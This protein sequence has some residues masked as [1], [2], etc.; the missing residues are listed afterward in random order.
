MNTYLQVQTTTDSE[1]AAKAL[2]SLLVERKLAACVQISSPIT[3]I[4]TWKDTITNAKEWL[5]SAK[6][7]A[8]LYEKIE[9]AIKESHSYE[10]PEIIAT[11]LECLSPDYA[12]WMEEQL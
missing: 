7:R 6:T 2:A 4:Y 10:L 1:E 11:K 3:S 12:T 8:D 5:I 9:Q